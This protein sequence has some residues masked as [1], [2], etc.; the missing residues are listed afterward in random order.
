MPVSFSS[1]LLHKVN[2]VSLIMCAVRNVIQLPHSRTL[3]GYSEHDREPLCY[4]KDEELH[5]HLSNYQLL[6]DSFSMEL[7][8]LNF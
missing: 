5:Y 7:V 3:V 4:V 8:F 2:Y 6:Q 1:N